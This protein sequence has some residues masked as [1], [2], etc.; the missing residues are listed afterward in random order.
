[1][2]APRRRV[3]A[4]YHSRCVLLLALLAAVPEP[5]LEE[6]RPLAPAEHP[7][8]D[9]SGVL[10]SGGL[11]AETSI[12]GGLTAS[13]A[14]ARIGM[15]E[16]GLEWAIRGGVGPT[17]GSTGVATDLAMEV[18]GRV[19]RGRWSLPLHIRAGALSIGGGPSFGLGFDAGVDLAVDRAL[20]L[21]I[22][23]FGTFAPALD[24]PYLA[25]ATIGV[26]VIP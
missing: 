13:L 16:Y 14:V 22:A 19:P 1:M 15:H 9:R 8:S 17:I 7:W 26:V 3:K 25:G 6:P 11:A 18:G 10:V 24:L 4:R 2:A 20:R 23:G 5:A 21:E 12:P